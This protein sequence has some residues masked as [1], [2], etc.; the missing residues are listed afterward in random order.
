M[1]LSN[2]TSLQKKKKSHLG[3]KKYTSIIWNT[4][5]SWLRGSW[6]NPS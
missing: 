3:K 1:L 4:H 2:P 6:N 5:L